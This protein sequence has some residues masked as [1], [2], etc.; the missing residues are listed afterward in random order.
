MKKRYIV[1]IAIA[2]VLLVAGLGFAGFSFYQVQMEKSKTITIGALLPLTG[3]LSSSAEDGKA[4]LQ[5]ALR[6][7][8]KDLKDRGSNKTVKVLVQDTNLNA[9]NALT[10]MRDFA[11]KNEV[12]FIIGPMSSDIVLSL[13]K[14]A[15]EDGVVL[16][17]PTS[18]APGLSVPGDNLFRL[19]SDDTHQAQAVATLMKEDGINLVVPISRGDVWGDEFRQA[20]IDKFE[21]LGG[22]VIEG[23]RYDVSNEDFTDELDT[24][25]GVVNLS[26]RKSGKGSVAVLVLAFDEVIK[27]FKTASNIRPLS[28]TKWYG[29]DAIALNKSLLADA[30]AAAFAE[31]V[32]LPCPVYASGENE[33]S[34]RLQKEISDILQREPSIAALTS[35]DALQLAVE[36]SI[37]SG[38]SKDINVL[39]TALF[40]CADSFYG[41][42]G[43][44]AFNAEGDRKI[45]NYDFW[46]IA[47]GQW[48]RVSRFQSDDN[49]GN[50]LIRFA[51]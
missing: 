25:T 23:V 14:Y 11:K 27:I 30:E 35:Y 48:K 1:I 22:E 31:K 39:K 40:Q 8:L 33:I 26:S 46:A 4:G 2:C 36:A 42:T 7:I 20:F 45:A 10:K 43:W 16:I 6:D 50:R 17:S 19:V 49:F 28:Q 38:F 34:S 13:N 5:I 18:S 3:K 37:V 24:L 29:S 15:V 21:A 47:D 12:K 44:C 32:G 51:D 9:A 41:A